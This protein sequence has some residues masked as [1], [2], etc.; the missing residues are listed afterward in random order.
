MANVPTSRDNTI[1]FGNTVLASRYIETP[2]IRGTGGGA[3]PI[4]VGTTQFGGTSTIIGTLDLPASMCIGEGGKYTESMIVQ[5]NTNGTAGTW[6][7]LTSSAAD[8]TSPPTIC[9]FT[10]K[11]YK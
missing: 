8:E 4:I 10:R 6:L 7:N 2:L 3:N 9:Y 11:Y 1:F 5:S